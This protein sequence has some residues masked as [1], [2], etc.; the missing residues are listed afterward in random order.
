MATLIVSL[1]LLAAGVAT[2][3]DYV[4]STDGLHATRHGRVTASLLPPLPGP[5]NDIVAVVP[6]RALSWHRVTLPPPLL[7]RGPLGRSGPSP[8]TRAALEGLL[9]DQLLD[10]P[11]SVHFALAP[12]SNGD[13][14]HWVAACDRAWLRSGLQVLDQARR[15]VSRIV[16]EYAPA[17]ADDA[18]APTL[19]ATPGLEP[20]QLVLPDDRGVTVLPLGAAAASW[21]AWPESADMVAEPG[22]A[23]LSEQTFKRTVS[24]QPAAQRWLQA[25]RC[26]WN[27]AQFDLASSG[28][29]RV[30]KSLASGWNSLRH[31]PQWQ[32]A[33]W[34]AG[35]LLAS[36][37]IGLN[38]LA[39]KERAVLEQKQAA[40]RDILLQTFPDVKIV[41]DAPVQMER[42]VYALQQTNGTVSPRDLEAMLVALSTAV[43]AGRAL[44]EIEF[45]AGEARLKGLQLQ[46]HEAADLTA[47]FQAT[48]YVMRVDGDQLVMRVERAP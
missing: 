11:A 25:A 12:E 29:T 7:G 24:L 4:M 3:F 19:Y 5:G 43:R 16:P 34:M 18:A 23:T 21:L 15:P 6:A 47:Q 44:S 46:G 17:T 37:L 28:R 48:G 13:G 41:L 14:T 42:E 39:W 10:E 22:V 33:R 45:T 38:A 31:A 40:I 30:L 9:E 1:P 8:Q 35:V 26:G 2:E 36:Q 20:A 32:A 27:L